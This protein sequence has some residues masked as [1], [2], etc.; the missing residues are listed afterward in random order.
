MSKVA[1]FLIPSIPLF[2]A[3]ALKRVAEPSSIDSELA[4][5]LAVSQSPSF[6][7]PS[8]MARVRFEL[9]RSALDSLMPLMGDV[10]VQAA[11]LT[12]TGTILYRS[13]CSS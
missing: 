2:S 4:L 6:L 7:S 1:W 11:L 5:N 10:D 3:A 8:D 12:I 9:N 13:N